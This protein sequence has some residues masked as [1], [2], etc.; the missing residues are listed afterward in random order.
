MLPLN[1]N[2]HSKKQTIDEAL[3]YIKA[4]SGALDLD[5]FNVEFKSSSFI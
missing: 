2:I 4:L 1:E 3:T 5:I